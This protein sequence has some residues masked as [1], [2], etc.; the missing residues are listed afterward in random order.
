MPHFSFC[1]FMYFFV[2]DLFFLSLLDINECS[3]FPSVC[4]INANCQN[5]AGSYVCSC[6]PGFNGDGK[7][8]QGTKNINNLIKIKHLLLVFMILSTT[9]LY[10]Y[11]IHSLIFFITTSIVP[12]KAEPE[13]SALSLAIWA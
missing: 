3:V 7:T 6:K 9:V 12:V 10:N 1:Q 11:S 5:S 8:C 4:H 2:S 13:Q